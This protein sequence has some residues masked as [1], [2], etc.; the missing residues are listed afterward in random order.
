MTLSAIK[1]VFVGFHEQRKIDIA[2]QVIHGQFSLV[3]GAT[4]L[5]KSYRQGRG[6]VFI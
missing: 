3:Q 2:Y 4:L 6:I 5:Q 1:G